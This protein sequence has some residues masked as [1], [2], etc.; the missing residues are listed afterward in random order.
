[1]GVTHAVCMSHSTVTCAEKDLKEL[2]SFLIC[3]TF[4]ISDHPV[5]EAT[6]VGLSTF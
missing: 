2:V 5:S 6:S 3:W 4:V 1:M